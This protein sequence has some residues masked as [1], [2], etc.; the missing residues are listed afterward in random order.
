MTTVVTER[1][2]I[3]ARGGQAALLL[4]GV[5]FV[6]YPAVRPYG[7]MQPASAA[8]AFASGAW[9]LAHLSA[10]VGFVLLPLGLLAVRTATGHT[11][12]AGAAFLVTWLGVGL[13]LPYYGAEVFA[14]HATGE[15]ILATGDESLLGLVDAVRNGSVQITAFGIGLLL[16]AVG[17]ALAAVAVCRSGV[18]ARW[19]AVPLAAGFVLFLPQFYAPPAL[20]IAHGVLLG[21]GCVLL[22]AELG[23]ARQRT[24]SSAR[25]RVVS[26]AS[27]ESPAG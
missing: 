4:A 11:R 27:T 9:V 26:R 2:V 3:T 7:D 15:R 24:R 10:V 20:R 21:V 8:A 13:V 23:R 6:L 14:L 17:A 22:A 18:L 12:V 16:L 5:L 19:S 1:P 25:P